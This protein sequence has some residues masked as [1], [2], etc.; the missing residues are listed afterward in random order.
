LLTPPQWIANLQ[1]HVGSEPNFLADFLDFL[2][3]KMLVPDLKDRGDCDD[4]CRFLEQ[5]YQKDPDKGH[6]SYWSPTLPLFQAAMKGNTTADPRV[7][8]RITDVHGRN[9]S[10]A[11]LSESL[12]SLRDTDADQ[13]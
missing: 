4:L 10:E 11:A 12:A 7:R 6:Q 2:T 5:C 8:I 1:R 13:T 3:D 9:N